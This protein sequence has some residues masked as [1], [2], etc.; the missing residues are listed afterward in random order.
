VGSDLDDVRTQRRIYELTV[1]GLIATV[2]SEIVGGARLTQITFP[3]APT[4]TRSA[5]GRPN[6]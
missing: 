5:D 6:V 3:A 1:P 4:C 2:A